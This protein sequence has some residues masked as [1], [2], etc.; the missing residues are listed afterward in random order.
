MEMINLSLVKKYGTGTCH[1]N[2]ARPTNNAS[3]TSGAP[4]ENRGTLFIV[5]ALL[6]AGQVALAACAPLSEEQVLEREYDRENKLLVAR[7][8]YLRRRAACKQRGGVMQ[9][10]RYSSTRSQ[11]FSAVEYKSAQCLRY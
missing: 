8:E 10:D 3:K 11:K 5:V 1:F 4:P 2:L 7:E 9:I 6:V